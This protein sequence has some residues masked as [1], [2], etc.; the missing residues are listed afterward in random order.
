MHIKTAKDLGAAIKQA[1]T[2]RRMSQAELA[3][4]LGVSQPRISEIERGSTGV[5]A[6]LILR[7]LHALDFTLAIMPADTAEG[8]PRLAMGQPEFVDLDAIANTG[9]DQWPTKR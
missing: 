5:A 3:K 7:I 9:L 6:G 4:V 8:G 2:L 1:R